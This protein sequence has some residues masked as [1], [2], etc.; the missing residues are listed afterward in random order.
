VATGDPRLNPEPLAAA[1]PGP[2]SGRQLASGFAW[3]Y[4]AYALGRLFFFGATLVLARELAPA[5][6]GLVAFTLALLAY[7]ETITSHGF[8][9]TLIYRADATDRRISS[10]TFWLSLLGSIVM[11]VA[12]WIAAPAIARL[13]PSSE[14]LVWI[15][16][17]LG[18]QL[19]LTGFG[20]AP[21]FLLRH[22]LSFRRVFWPQ[23]AS[24]MAKGLVAVGLALAGAGVWSL[25]AGQL[26]GSLV[27]SVALWR[28]SRFR[29]ALAIARRELRSITSAGA[30]F[31]AIAIIAELARNADYLI[32]GAQLGTT[33]LGFYY[34]A[35]RLPELVLLSGFQAFWH[36]L[37]PYYSRLRD[38]AAD[39]A[40]ARERLA[41]ALRRT[42]RLGGLVALPLGAVLAALADPLISVLYGDRWDPAALPAALI[43]LWA[44]VSAVSGLAGITLKALGRTGTLTVAMS[45]S[46]VLRLPLLWVAASWS[47]SA[48]A[49]TQL[50]AQAIWLVAIY[51]VAAR[52]LQT[53]TRALL[54]RL[55]PGLA[56]AVAVAAPALVAAQTLPPGAALVA[57]FAAAAV[58]Y[59][60]ALASAGV[61]PARLLSAYRFRSQLPSEA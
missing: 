44:G 2:P 11:F 29:P 23:V 18:L 52:S 1:A 43:A 41:G 14:T 4:G 32:V 57:G 10:T 51:A 46:S 34:L 61:R 21:D 5:E 39:A 13:G 56:I 40:A 9:E 54:V 6:F 33:A 12:L 17:I 48:V 45:I 49:A 26:S 16:R 59:V 15:V 28:V 7:L 42:I 25:V 60:V 24:G 3:H 22:S 27:R 38:S 20:S 30:G 8:G 19:V 53:M 50:I 47:I 55:L 35:F 36:V 37:F 58:V 31:A